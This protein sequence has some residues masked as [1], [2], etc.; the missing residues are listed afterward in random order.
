MQKKLYKIEQGKKM[1]GV[2]MGFAEYL[3]TDVTIIRLLW[4]VGTII[5]G[6]W[7]GLLLYVAC[8]FIMPE[9]PECYDAEYTEK[10]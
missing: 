4:V 2:C 3:N 5:T 1:S 8:A 9:E 10:H 6:F 7:L